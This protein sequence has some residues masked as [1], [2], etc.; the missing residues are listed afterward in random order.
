LLL[1]LCDCGNAG[2]AVHADHRGGRADGLA[3]A[4]S[5]GQPH[6][7][8]SGG[9]EWQQPGQ[10]EHRP[11]DHHRAGQCCQHECA[12]APKLIYVQVAE[13][14][15]ARIANGQLAPGARLPAE[16]NLASEYGVAYDTIRRATALLRSQGLIITI[17]GRGT[18]V[19]PQQPQSDT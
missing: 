3:L 9:S 12:H 16:R 11:T 13:H 14:I 6:A 8:D 2:R 18:F 10:Q 1:E 19:A 4:R 7:S 17:A 15:A 5:V